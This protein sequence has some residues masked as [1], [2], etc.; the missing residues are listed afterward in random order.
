MNKPSEDVSEVLCGQ[1]LVLDHS[2]VG[3]R[4]VVLFLKEKKKPQGPWMTLSAF[5]ESSDFVKILA[6]YF[7]I[8]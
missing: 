6:L 5:R 8:N 4:A 1:R 2:A 7:I 3:F